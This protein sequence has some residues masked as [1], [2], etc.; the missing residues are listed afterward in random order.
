MIDL[1]LSVEKKFEHRD[2]RSKGKDV[3]HRTQHI[4]EE[5]ESDVEFIGRNVMRHHFE[6]FFHISVGNAYSQ[7]GKS[8]EFERQ[9]YSKKTRF[10]GIFPMK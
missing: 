1:L 8:Y 6:E 4:E 3:E 10:R 2:E 7:L 5:G 9:K